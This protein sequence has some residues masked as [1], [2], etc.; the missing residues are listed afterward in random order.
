MYM[1]MVDFLV[2]EIGSVGGK[3]VV[4]QGDTVEKGFFQG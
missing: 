3:I 1:M 4:Q 2:V